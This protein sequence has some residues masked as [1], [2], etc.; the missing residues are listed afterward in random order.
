MEAPS[1]RFSGN[2]CTALRN[3]S[4]ILGYSQ[5]RLEVSFAAEKRV[6]ASERTNYC[7]RN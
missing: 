6:T 3:R 5:Y 1:E 4:P 2:A 7:S